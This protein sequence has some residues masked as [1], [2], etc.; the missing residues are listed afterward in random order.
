VTDRLPTARSTER[1]GYLCVLV[2]CKACRRQAPAD[3][4][5]II[6]AGK[7]DV[8]LIELRFRCANCGSRLT[9]SVVAAKDALSVEPWRAPGEGC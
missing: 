8:P 4:A 3:L 5:A 2:W 7:G 9:D 1:A 6:A